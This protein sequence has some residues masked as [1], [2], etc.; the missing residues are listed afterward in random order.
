MTLHRDGPASLT[1]IVL[2]GQATRDSVRRCAWGI[3]AASQSAF[4]RRMQKSR[5]CRQMSVT[6]SC[7]ESSSP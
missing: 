4:H 3:S 1:A 6:V 2:V 7:I 5:D